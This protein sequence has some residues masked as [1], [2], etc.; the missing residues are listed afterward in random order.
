MTGE[1]PR[2]FTGM[3][4][5]DL[6]QRLSAR[7]PSPGGGAAAAV[8]AAI[9]CATGA[10]AARYTTGARWADRQAA[11]QAL[12][13]ELD[14]AAGEFLNLAEE[15]AAAYEALT[16]ARRTGVPAELARAEA[17]SSAAPAEVLARCALQ[18]AGLV[19]FRPTC[20]PQL[21]GDIDVAI[22]L[23]AGAGRAARALLLASPVAAEVL[24]AAQA[25]AASLAASQ[26]ACDAAR[27]AARDVGSRAPGGT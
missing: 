1:V 2:A 4:I 8:T 11:A 12:A 27:D 10:M 25:H 19:G 7:T 21:R 14:E 23:L 17:R 6:L 16:A 3:P 18:A 13:L 15:D 5:G 22:A 9:G 24:S 26:S 20:N